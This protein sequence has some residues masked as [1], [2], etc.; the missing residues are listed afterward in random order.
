MALH[1]LRYDEHCPLPV[2]VVERKKTTAKHERLPPM[3][4]RTI[5][6]PPTEVA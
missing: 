1:L 3:G 4:K 6:S 5:V 2:K